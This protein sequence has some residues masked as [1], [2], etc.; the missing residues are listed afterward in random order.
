L[1]LLVIRLERFPK[2]TI[3]IFL[4]VLENDRIEPCV[5][6]E[7]IVASTALADAG[8]EVFGMGVSCA[9]VGLPLHPRIIEAYRAHHQAV[10]E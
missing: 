8:I 5:A 4:T 1:I 7:S 9:V 2:S 3:D 6:A 10:I